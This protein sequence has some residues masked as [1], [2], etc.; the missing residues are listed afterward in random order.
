MIHVSVNWASE[1]G[2]LIGSWLSCDNS[3]TVGSIFQKFINQNHCHQ[4]SFSDSGLHIFQV[5]LHIFNIY[6][7]IFG[8]IHICN[9]PFLVDLCFYMLSYDEANYGL[10]PS[11]RPAFVHPSTQRLLSSN[12]HNS[13]QP[14]WIS[15][16]RYTAIP[17]ENL[18]RFTKFKGQ[19]HFEK[20]LQQNNLNITHNFLQPS[21]ISMKHYSVIPR[22]APVCV[23][24]FRSSGPKVKVTFEDLNQ[25]LGYCTEIPSA[26]MYFNETLHSVSL[27]DS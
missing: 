1:V 23:L 17:W 15:M 16:K 4:V 7:Y 18:N 2:H 20:K 12:S 6:K 27:R 3:V 26:F 9:L 11:V 13:L 25:Q 24:D 10:C 5:I 19:G 21:Q 14:L 22:G 8:S